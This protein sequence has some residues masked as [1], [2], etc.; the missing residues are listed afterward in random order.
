M[1]PRP[2]SITWLSDDP[3][4]IKQWPLTKDKLQAA[5]LLVQEQL[6]VGHIVPSTSP[7][8]TPI[9]VIRKGSGKWRLLQDL[10]AINNTM[11][12]M[13]PLQPGLP[14]P[15]AIPKDWHLI[16]LDLKDCFFSIPLAPQD[17]KRFAFSL[18]SI[19]FREPYQR[20]KWTVL[21]QEMANSPT[22]C[23]YFIAKILQPFRQQFP[24]F[25]LVHYM[26]DILLAG[27]DRKALFWSYEVLQSLLKGA[28]LIIA[29]EKVQIQYPYNYLGYT[30]NKVGITPQRPQFQ[31]N[32]LKT[33]HQWQT[34]LG[35][36]QWLRPSLHVP[37]GELKPLYDLLR[38]DPSPTSP[39]K[40][41]P[42]ALKAL[43]LIETALQEMQVMQV[44]YSQ[45]LLF[46]VLPSK[47]TP[48]GVFWQ[49]GPI[50]WVHLPASPSR[51]LIPFHDLVIQLV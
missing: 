27:P 46:I 14:F 16:I 18:P 2:L 43:R 21:P 41:T 11:Q 40:P 33:L 26:D 42:E 3:V 7:W 29:P 19:N 39:R 50:Y 13:G 45:S 1:W 48:T 8:N 51:V 23:Q 34:F 25:Y 20:F 9:F 6:R 36:I 32:Q 49:T 17:C 24:N 12:P 15:T 30:I 5:T 35:K 22:M 10:R 37:T 31:V 28:G 38:G 47:L 4:W 44:D